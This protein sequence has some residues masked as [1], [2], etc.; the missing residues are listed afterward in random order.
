MKT[1]KAKY[2]VYAYASGDSARGYDYETSADTL[3]EARKRARY[4]LSEEFRLSGEMSHRLAM[5]KVFNGADECVFD[6]FRTVDK[7]ISRAAM[8]LAI[9][10]HVAIYDNR[11]RRYNNARSVLGSPDGIELCEAGTDNWLPLTAD[12]V[13]RSYWGNPVENPIK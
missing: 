11:G 7:T 1:E 5:A 9:V 8:S 6:C 4:C 10:A 3:A 13:L 12:L 2:T